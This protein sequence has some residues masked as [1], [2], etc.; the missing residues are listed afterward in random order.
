MCK[1]NI[2]KVRKSGNIAGFQD[3]SSGGGLNMRF[4]PSPGFGIEEWSKYNSDSV[5]LLDFD[6]G[7]C[8]E[9]CFWE[10]DT[11]K[12]KIMVSLY[13]GRS[14]P[15]GVLTWRIKDGNKI[16]MRGFSQ[17]ANIP[18]GKVT[19]L[20][21]IEFNWPEISKNSK[22]NL[23]IRLS[24][25]GYN[26]YNDWD[27]WVFKKEKVEVKAACTPAVYGS[28]KERY[29][30]IN[31]L[32]R[33]SSEKLWITNSL[34]KTMINHLAKGGDVLLIGGKPFP[35][36][37]LWPR[38]RQGW[39]NY[40]EQGR[41]VH[42]HP[43]FKNIPN[44][45]WGNWQFYPLLEGAYPVVFTNKRLMSAH[46]AAYAGY[47]VDSKISLMKNVPFNPI[48]E[49]ITIRQ[50]TEEAYIF[51]LKAGKGRLF[52]TT[53]IY[54]ENPASVVLMD[55][56][57]KYVTGKEFLPKKEVSIETLESL[58]GVSSVSIS[59]NE[60]VFKPGNFIGGSLHPKY[61]S[62]GITPRDGLVI[63]SG[64]KT[65]IEFEL[66]PQ[67]IL[68][69]GDKLILSIDGQDCDKP[70]TT[71]IEILLN[72]NLLFKGVNKCVKKGWSIWDMPFNKK[73][74]RTGINNIEFRNMEKSALSGHKWF[75][76]AAV[77]IKAAKPEAAV[78]KISKSSVKWSNK[79][80]EINFKTKKSYKINNGNWKEGRRIAIRT[81][82]RNKVYIKEGKEVNIIEANIDITS[83]K[84]ALISIPL[85]GQL[86]GEYFATKETIFAISAKDNLS[87]IKGIEISIDKE[88]Y[89]PYNGEEFKLSA[90]RHSIRSR[91]TDY[92][93]NITDV[94]SSGLA[95]AGTGGNVQIQIK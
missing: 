3:L 68:T 63:G 5:I 34:T 21:D 55:S 54:S 26:I 91:C 15:S 27:F 86:A 67:Q 57:M 25:F 90:G 9:R 13:G 20:A 11:F 75:M 51:E 23:E 16:L 64:K 78:K 41:I 2:E 17:P 89:K 18:D 84:L 7:N 92:A 82:G 81:E 14:I 72:D 29:S 43:V 62:F 38:F 58:A 79:S 76:I 22:L 74:L 77:K 71:E 10:K 66:G 33:T 73:L 24:G 85:I 87:G 88:E 45:G 94:F 49:P 83:P 32:K 36:Y 70:E 4:D 48:L 65:N 39:T 69:K 46:A 80:V 42:N 53:C 56:I 30:D 47:S 40:H 59:N 6:N 44:E 31:R 50:E 35:L 61:S 19:T 95:G 1:Y 37:T 28:L 8:F 93:G 52:V 12:A 60:I